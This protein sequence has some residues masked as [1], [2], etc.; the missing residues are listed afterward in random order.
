MISFALF[1]DQV[2]AGTSHPILPHAA[3]LSSWGCH[4]LSVLIRSPW[5]ESLRHCR[6]SLDLGQENQGMA[7][8]GV[9]SPPCHDIH[10]EEVCDELNIAVW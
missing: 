1:P 3:C 9:R 6:I 10:S 7:A 5:E 8:T 2:T 4:I